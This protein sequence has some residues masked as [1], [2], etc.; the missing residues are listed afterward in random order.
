MQGKPLQAY[1][2]PPNIFYMHRREDN[3]SYGG[4]TLLPASHIS[5]QYPSESI[6]ARQ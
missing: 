2:L 3:P 6:S 5:G 1:D 4:N